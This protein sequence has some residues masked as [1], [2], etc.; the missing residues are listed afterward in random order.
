MS[1][2]N[3]VNVKIIY[4][5]IKI[6]ALLTICISII[7]F[8]IIT[9]PNFQNLGQILII[10]TYIYGFTYVIYKTKE[11][12]FLDKIIKFT[13]FILLNSPLF[14]YSLVLFFITYPN[15]LIKV[16]DSSAW[17]SF[18]G[19]IIGG[20]LV[21]FA[22]IFTIQN[23]ERIR[24]NNRL[25]EIKRTKL[26]L[27]PIIDYDFQITQPKQN[28]KECFIYGCIDNKSDA[29]AKIF[30]I[31]IQGTLVKLDDLEVDIIQ[32]YDE[33]K[34]SYS[35]TNILY[36]AGKSKKDYPFHIPIDPERRG[37]IINNHN[38]ATYKIVVEIL[39]TDIQEIQKYSYT[40]EKIIKLGTKNIYFENYI[41]L[42]SVE[43]P[44]IT[45][46]NE[47]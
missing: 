32:T 12:D 35:T 1:K 29:H 8:G 11:D 30:E 7:Q 43:V 17:I 9:L 42:K 25:I 24:E 14:I 19:S 23:E 16:G 40:A 33:E 5:Y 20:S 4:G 22:L 27:M 2:L 31:K 15:I 28:S 6:P 38:Y 13:I 44:A 3:S 46:I 36:V 45:L 47:I 10:T 41:D 21:M 18:A 26:N 37:I 39:Y 34:F